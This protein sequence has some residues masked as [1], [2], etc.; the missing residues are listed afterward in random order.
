VAGPWLA[1]LCLAPA[2]ADEA[3]AQVQAL[4]LLAKASN[5]RLPVQSPWVAL[6][7]RHTEI[8]RKLAAELALPPGQRGRVWAGPSPSGR[9][10][11]QPAGSPTSTH[12]HS[13]PRL[14]DSG[15]KPEA[16]R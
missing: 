5:T 12:R 14:L 7:N 8:A 4:G 2:Y 6:M 11:Y 16:S 9:R 1:R 3:T 10:G 15:I 13:P